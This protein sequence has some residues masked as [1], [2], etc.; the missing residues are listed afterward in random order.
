MKLVTVSDWAGAEATLEIL[1]A[2]CVP[3]VGKNVNEV[4]LSFKY[5][6]DKEQLPLYPC[7]L[8]GTVNQSTSCLFDD[9]G[10]Y[11]D[12]SHHHFKCFIAR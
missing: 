3:L 11:H 8:T 4:H 9:T 6:Q 1:T 5:Y 2:L 7:Y 12:E 10:S